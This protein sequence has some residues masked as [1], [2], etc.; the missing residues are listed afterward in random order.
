MLVEITTWYLEMLDPKQLRSVPPGDYK[1][2]IEQAKIPSPEFSR[3]LYTSVGGDWYWIDRLD[4]NY[5]R[6]LAY[7]NRP[8]LETWV[9]YVSGTPAGYI[10]LEVQPD[11]NVQ[12]AYFGIMRQ[13]VGQRLGGHLLSFGVERAWKIGAVRVWVHTCSLDGPFAL[14][15]YLARGFQI[16]QQEVHTQELPNQPIGAWQ[17]AYD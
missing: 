10:E 11:H 7:L 17:G 4:W 5:E 16:Y 6:W 15:N 2:L 3:F 12:I 14:A 1:L 9:A 8:E 13:F